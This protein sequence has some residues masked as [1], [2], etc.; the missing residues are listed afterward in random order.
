MRSERIEELRVIASN[1][2]RPGWYGY[3]IAPFLDETIEAL[4]AAA[5]EITKLKE[6]LREYVDTYDGNTGAPLHT[7][8]RVALSDLAVMR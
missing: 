7:E 3:E 4:D 1:A 6:L 2:R 5:T 8:A